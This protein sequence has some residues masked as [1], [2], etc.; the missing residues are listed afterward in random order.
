VL[1]PGRAAAEPAGVPDSA[2]GVALPPAGTGYLATLRAGLAFAA[3]RPALL[4]LV[5]FSALALVLYGSLEEY[6]AL[7]AR[8]SALPEAW[9]GL[10]LAA[11][12][13]SQALGAGQAWRLD[14]G[15][16]G[17]STPAWL[18]LLAGALLLACGL[19]CSP[20]GLACLLLFCLL[21]TAAETLLAGRLQELLPDAQ[22]ATLGSFS[23]L[24]GEVWA[25]AVYAGVGFIAGR[26]SYAL[27]FAAGGILLLLLGLA[28]RARPAPA[29]G[30]QP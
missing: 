16:R 19:L 7:L 11:I 23:G 21:Y 15:R 28:L 9:Q 8:D 18:L 25:V 29:A 13:A 4:S 17:L 10:L 2:A 22:R 5:L 27:A 26:W 20:L 1:T 14:A 30:A 3:R 24:A 12:A 6:F